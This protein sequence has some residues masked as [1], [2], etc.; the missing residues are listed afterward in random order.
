MALSI[1]CLIEACILI[2]NALAILNPKYFLKNYGLDSIDNYDLVSV[3]WKRQ[4][5]FL[6][7]S[8]RTYGRLPLIFLNSMIIVLEV[9]LG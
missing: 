5:A 6:L 1:F 4:L 8:A 2:L 3:P 7:Y 9:L